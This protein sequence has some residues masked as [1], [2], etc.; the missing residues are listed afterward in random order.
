VT[1]DLDVI[2]AQDKPTSVKVG[3]LPYPKMVDA[4]RSL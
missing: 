1:L 4:A 2:F 3:D